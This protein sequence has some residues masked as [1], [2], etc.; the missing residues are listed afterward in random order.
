MYDLGTKNTEEDLNADIINADLVN[1][2]SASE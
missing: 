2:N 1:V